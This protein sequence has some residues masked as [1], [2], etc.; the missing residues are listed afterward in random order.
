[1]NSARLRRPEATTRSMQ[2]LTARAGQN[3][4]AARLGQSDPKSDTVGWLGP[5]L[6]MG[7][8]PE[9]VTAPRARAAAHRWTT[10]H[11]VLVESTSSD[12]GVRLA[13]PHRQGLTREALQRR[14][15]E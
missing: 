7:R 5:A 14:G 12:G 15:A 3:A 10:H 13:M 1:V 4:M 11:L 2:Q 6:C 9:A 8:A